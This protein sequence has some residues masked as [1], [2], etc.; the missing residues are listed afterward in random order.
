VFHGVPEIGGRFSALSSF[1]VV[2]ATL[3]GLDPAELLD[4][5][6]RMVDAC[7]PG[8]S[9]QDNPGVSTAASTSSRS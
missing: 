3:M 8:V 7:R 9:A 5:A 4:E 6:A 1:G 2:P